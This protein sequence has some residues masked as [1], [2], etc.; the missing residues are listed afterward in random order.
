RLRVV[1]AIGLSPRH[2]WALEGWHPGK[3]ALVHLDVERPHHLA[4]LLGL[5]GKELREIGR[6]AGKR[7]AA[8]LGKPCPEAGIGEGGVD[9][10]VE[11]IDDLSR[12]VLRCADADPGTRLIT[13]YKVR[14]GRDL[15]QRCRARRGGHRERAYRSRPDVADRRRNW[16][17]QDL[18]LSGEQIGL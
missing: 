7:H 16:A 2:S 10:P 15:R 5:L 13:G 17:E 9:L 11:R 4:P 18:D 12:R 1:V 3:A 8:G 14:Y 6:R